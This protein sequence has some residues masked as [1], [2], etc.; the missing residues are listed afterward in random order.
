MLESLNPDLACHR[1]AP[2]KTP[3]RRLA[4]LEAAGEL[5]IPFTTGHPRR[6]RREPGRPPRRPRGDRRQPRRH[7]HVQEVIVQNFLPKPGTAMHAAPPCPP[8]EFLWT[9]RRRPPRPARRRPPPGPAQP[10]RR[11]RRAARRRHRRLGRRLARHRRPRQPRAPVARPSTGCGR[12]PRPRGFALAPR[13]TIYPEYALDPDRWLDAGAALRRCIDRSRRRG[14]GPRPRPLVLAAAQDP[15]APCSSPGRRPGPAGPAG[16]WPR[17]STACSPARRS[18]ED[19]I[20]TLFSARGPEVAAVAEVADELRRRV[21]RRRRH[22]G[23]QPQHQ[24]HERLHVQVPVLRLL[25]GPA[26][27]EPAGHALPARRST[28]SPA[29]WSRRGPGRHRGL[30]AGRHPPR[31]STATTTST[32]PGR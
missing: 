13:L 2:D 3:E 20:V 7:G 30:P 6:H 18:G 12:S 4:T 10:V 16:R 23:P 24:L 27:A 29:G 21:S 28:T 22:L 1:G 17:S 31:A 15:P 19:E 26:V 32:S 11:L 9:R 14:P 8:D 5:A 25:Q